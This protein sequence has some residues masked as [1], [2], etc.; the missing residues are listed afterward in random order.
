MSVDTSRLR[1][2]VGGIGLSDTNCLSGGIIGTLSDD[3]GQDNTGGWVG[4]LI[5]PWSRGACWGITANKVV[6]DT[7]CLHAHLHIVSMLPHHSMVDPEPGCQHTEGLL[8]HHSCLRHA[9]VEHP[10]ASAE[11]PSRIWTHQ[12]TAQREG[13]VPHKGV[14]KWPEILCSRDDGIWWDSQGA[15]WRRSPYN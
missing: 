9:V 4:H 8:Y 5:L 1:G 3:T 7:G 14:S 11:V 12:V 10:T 2:K 13:F 15:R 6:E